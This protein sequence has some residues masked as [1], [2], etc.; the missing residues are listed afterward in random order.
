MVQLE[1][2]VLIKPQA[3]QVHQVLQDLLVQQVLTVLQQYQVR[4]AQL[5]PQ[6]Q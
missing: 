5:V 6:E 2:V 4:Q 1:Q 3:F